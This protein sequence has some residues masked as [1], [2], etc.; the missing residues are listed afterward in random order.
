MENP[1]KVKIWI[2]QVPANLCNVT[3]MA[4]IFISNFSG[5]NTICGS[6]SSSAEV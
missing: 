3:F 1:S 2:S 5:I 4:E 6:A